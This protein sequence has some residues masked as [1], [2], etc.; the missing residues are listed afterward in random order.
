MSLIETLPLIPFGKY[1]G[2]P[3]TE[4]ISDTEYL[5][6]L[7]LQPWFKEKHPT[8]YNITINQ[9][10]SNNDSKTPE[11]NK[12]QNMFLEENFCISIFDYLYKD[13][14]I[15]DFTIL[16]KL[17]SNDNIND[18]IMEHVNNYIKKIDVEFEAK[19]NWDVVLFPDINFKSII[20]PID[21]KIISSELKTIDL[22]KGNEEGITNCEYKYK[23]KYKIC[24]EIKPILGD[25]Y[26]CVLRKIKTQIM[27]MGTPRIVRT[28]YRNITNYP[29]PC[30][31]VLLIK[32]FKSETT[33]EEQLVKIFKQS[34]IKVIFLNKI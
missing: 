21:R 7:S 12:I 34:N 25:D 10:I 33:S 8:I 17:I 29:E 20:L 4:I 5:K 2:K 31:F 19:Y 6:W 26:P 1:K 11:H 18:I 9:T 16:Y 15:N 27:L 24:I 13:N 32:E 22:C 23:L 14:I 3:V 30:V 28:G